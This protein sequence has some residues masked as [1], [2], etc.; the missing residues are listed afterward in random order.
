[1]KILLTQLSAFHL[2]ANQQFIDVILKLPE[3]LQQQDV[4]ASYPS[5]HKTLLHLWDAESIW[6]QRLKLQVQVVPPSANFGGDTAEVCKSLMN[7]SR[8]WQEWVVASTDRQLNHEFIYYNLKKEKFKQPVYQ[9]LMHMYNH[10]TYHRGQL[11][12][13]L[14][15][16]QV[17]NIPSTDFIVWSRKKTIV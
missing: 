1:M 15:Q 17:G 3:E 4:A 7:Q 2:W 6:W 8:L 5:L 12:C 9:M 11:V 10:G 13:M 16:L 14:R